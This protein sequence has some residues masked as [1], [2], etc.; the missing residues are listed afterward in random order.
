MIDFLKQTFGESVTEEAITAFKSELGKKFVAKADYNTKRD[1]LNEAREKISLLEAQADE[2]IK[3]ADSKERLQQEFDALKQKYDEH[4]SVLNGKIE[5]MKTES[6]ISS[7]IRKSG[8][9]N[10]KAVRAL[11]DLGDENIM[12]NAKA[13]LDMLKKSDPYLFDT[14]MPDGAK[15]NFPR[16]SFAGKGNLT[17]SQM[18]QLEANKNF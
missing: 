5:Q 9:K 12:E 15:G 7:L 18:M 3:N 1:E 14:H 4:V 16:S 11:L 6:D 8:G 10:E 13:Q 17:Y 2:Y